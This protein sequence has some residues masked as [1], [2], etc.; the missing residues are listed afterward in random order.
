MDRGGVNDKKERRNGQEA[1]SVDNYWMGGHLEDAD[2]A[3]YQLIPGPRYFT[4]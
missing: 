4:Y 1:L 2:T 3:A